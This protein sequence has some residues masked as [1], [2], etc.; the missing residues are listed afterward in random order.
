MADGG[1]GQV[2]LAGSCRPE[3]SGRRIFPVRKAGCYASRGPAPTY[4]GL[5]TNASSPMG[6]AL[7]P[8]PTFGERGS[9]NK[10]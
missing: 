4:G 3:C 2:T 9:E 8:E 10:H 6:P 5:S 1:Y 7:R